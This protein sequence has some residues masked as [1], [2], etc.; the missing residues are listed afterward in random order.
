[1]SK[2]VVPSLPDLSRVADPAA[3]EALKALTTGWQIRNG[4]AGSGE[5]KFLTKA[6]LEGFAVDS[7][8]R[9]LHAGLTA[10][11]RSVPF[12]G[13]PRPGEISRI[14]ADLANMVM[15]SR[16]FAELGTRIDFIDKPTT[17][18]I[19]RLGRA[20]I[21]LATEKT[22]RVSD[23]EALKI[24]TQTQ[25]ALFNQNMA[26]VQTQQSTI[27]NNVSSLAQHV[28]T[29]QASVG[30]L[31]NDALRLTAAVQQN[32]EATADVD[33]NLR[34]TYTLRTDVNGHVAGFGLTN[35]L[36]DGRQFSAFGVRADQFWIASDVDPV[37]AP[38]Q[39]PDP[40]K[41]PFVV[42]TINWRD[43]NGVMQPPGVYMNTAVID[44]AWIDTANIRVAA[45]DTLS[46][47]GEAVTVPTAA[48][49]P[50]LQG[51]VPYLQWQEILSC[52][53]NY[54]RTP[55]DTT[56]PDNVYVP[57]ARYIFF[58][59]MFQSF[60]NDDLSM[61][62]RILRNGAVIFETGKSVK[63]QFSD[64]LAAAKLDTDFLAPGIYRY[65]VEAMMDFATGDLRPNGVSMIV[66]GAKR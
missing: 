48:Q 8:L 23:V 50:T 25:Y 54:S 51:P 33:G 15:T 28:T 11:N 58:T 60:G 47:R 38:G 35:D 7:M 4:Q 45:V 5:N 6:D 56:S 24:D 12:S 1:V 34:A 18:L 62:V 39:A 32:I 37:L 63:S 43:S 65:S 49:N 42:M 14:L 13:V 41:V 2:P 20:E 3:R 44:F 21:G 19:A 17:G 31:Q 9:G 40:A 26:I 64:Q 30:S 53:V 61:H 59:G 27:A 10:S 55:G 46:I 52:Q 16:L 22:E 57:S 36:I 66:L 29:V